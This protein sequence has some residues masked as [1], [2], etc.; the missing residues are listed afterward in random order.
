[1][2]LAVTSPF[3]NALEIFLKIYFKERDKMM[4]SLLQ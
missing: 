4:T 3:H 2:P 1:M